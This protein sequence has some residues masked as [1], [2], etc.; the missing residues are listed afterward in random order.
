[1][2]SQGIN[3]YDVARYVGNSPEVIRK[4]YLKHIEKLNNERKLQRQNEGALPNDPKPVIQ[5]VK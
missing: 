2:I 5:I 4:N 1:M 3:E